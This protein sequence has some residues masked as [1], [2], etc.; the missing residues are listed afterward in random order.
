MQEVSGVRVALTFDVD[1]FA[2]WLSDLGADAPGPLSRGEYEHVGI[3]RTLALLREYGIGATFFTTGVTAEVFPAVV[4]TIVEDGH[5]LAHHGW[6]HEHPARLSREAERDALERGLAALE[7]VGG[8]RPLGYRAPGVAPS[9]STVEL[10]LEHGFEYDSSL[11]GND[12]EPYWGR[13]G[14]RWSTTGRYE[15]GE[16][17][18]L[19]ELPFSHVLNDWQYFTFL[20]EPVSVAG[21]APPSTVLEIW[22]GEF[23]YLRERVGR[24]VLVITMHPQVIGP[25][26]RQE[27]LRMFIEH[28]RGSQ[29]DCF[30]RCVDYTRAWRS[31]RTPEL[32]TDLSPKEVVPRD[33][34]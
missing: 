3:R 11:S 19:V 12:Y 13:V 8:V 10:L 26:H 6:A 2:G 20:V 7:R 17:V 25:G 23:D 5:E 21:L 32:P 1:G 29:G 30:T 15:F 18:A 27:M 22:K 31:R 4:E 9:A 34:S 16:P 14:D 33:G 24:G 28:V